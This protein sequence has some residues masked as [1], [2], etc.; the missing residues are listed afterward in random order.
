MLKL[1]QHEVTTP[2]LPDITRGVKQ[3]LIMLNGKH[4][5][6]RHP[7]SSRAEEARTKQCYLSHQH[8]ERRIPWVR[9]KEK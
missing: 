7:L 5:Q 1:A 8:L 6:E 2:D 9:G 3:R 4:M